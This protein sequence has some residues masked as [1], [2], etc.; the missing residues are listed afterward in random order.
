MF[1]KEGTVWCR[2]RRLVVRFFQAILLKKTLTRFSP[3]N[4]FQQPPC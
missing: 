3:N 4:V 2:H 1:E